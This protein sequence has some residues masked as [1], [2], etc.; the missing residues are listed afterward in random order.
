[1]EPQ[2]LRIEWN[3]YRDG[4]DLCGRKVIIECVVGGKVMDRRKIASFPLLTFA[5]R[6]ER[7]KARMERCVRIMLR[8]S[9]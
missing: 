7:R 5:R 2:T 6:L 3:I 9:A 4:V 1:M 8:A